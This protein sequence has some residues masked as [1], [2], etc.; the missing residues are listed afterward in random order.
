MKLRKALDLR[1]LGAVDSPVTSCLRL[2]LG[3]G[4]AMVKEMPRC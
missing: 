2:V 3:V 1:P 4:V